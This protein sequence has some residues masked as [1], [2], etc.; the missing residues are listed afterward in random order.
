[1]TN[2]GILENRYFYRLKGLAVY[3]EDPE[4]T[5]VGLISIKT[6]NIKN[7]DQNHGLIPLKNVQF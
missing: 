7:C 4:D 3:L 5:F 1:M 2:F 6:N